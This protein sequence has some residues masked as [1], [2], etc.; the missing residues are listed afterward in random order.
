M[1]VD[2]IEQKLNI[3][4]KIVDDF[5]TFIIAIDKSGYD[6]DDVIFIRWLYK[7]NTHEFNKVNRSQYGRGIDF[8]QDNVEYIGNY[9]YVPTSGNCFT[10]CNIYLTG[11]EY[12]EEFLTFIRTK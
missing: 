7:L 10:E 4:F 6:S 9:C 5:E 1:F 8:K 11:K 12:T 3:R 2:E